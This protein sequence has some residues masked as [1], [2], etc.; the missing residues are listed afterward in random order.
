MFICEKFGINGN[1]FETNILNL[2][3]V[4]G[5][6]VYYGRIVFS[7]IINSYKLT[8]MKK[9]QEAENRF[10]ETENSLLI[11]RKNFEIA[12]QKAD[13]IR[14]QS[15]VLSKQTYKSLLENIDNEVKLLNLTNATIIKSEEE[16]SIN[17]ICQNLTNVALE[18][19]IEKL[20]SK[21]LNSRKQKKIISRKISKLM[22]KK[23]IYR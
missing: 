5:V 2:S 10:L 23:I 15:M 3:V 18:I 8:I 4:L 20:K 7:D 11:A 6:L 13:E 12:K 14:N 21:R 22:S 19:S 1:I 16:K 9:L 17:E